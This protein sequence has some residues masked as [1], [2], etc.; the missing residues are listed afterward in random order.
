MYAPARYRYISQFNA[1]HWRRDYPRIPRIIAYTGHQQSINF[2][3]LASFGG[4][5]TTYTV[6]L[7]LIEK[8][9]VDFLFVIIE[10]F[11]LG[12][13]VLS[14]FMRVTDGRVTSGQSKGERGGTAFPHLLFSASVVPHLL[15]LVSVVPPPGFKS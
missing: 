12:A 1:H 5:G 10:L 7:R 13:F 8:L 2:H 15:F 4:L 3:S 6:H 14:Q 9:V 11:S